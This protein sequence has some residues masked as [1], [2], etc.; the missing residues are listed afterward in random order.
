MLRFAHYYRGSSS[1]SNTP[2]VVPRNVSRTPTIGQLGPHFPWIVRQTIEQGRVSIQ[3][4][5]SLPQI[6][7][8]CQVAPTIPAL[9][10]LWPSPVASMIAESPR[11]TITSACERWFSP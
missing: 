4:I 10:Q 7:N 6:E 8:F 2:L 3:F 9:D 1:C 11:G 5:L